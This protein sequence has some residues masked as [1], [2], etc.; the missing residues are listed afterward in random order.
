MFTVTE[1]NDGAL[2]RFEMRS[3]TG[4]LESSFK[5]NPYDMYLPQKMQEVLNELKMLKSKKV[6]TPE[7]W[8]AFDEDLAYLL[9]AALG[10]NQEGSMFRKY[11]PTEQLANGEVLC[12]LIVKEVCKQCKYYVEKRR[13]M[14]AQRSFDYKKK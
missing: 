9:S 4:E 7:E 10:G 8:A 11:A 14:F 3:E 2:L 6:T 13:A 12:V 1:I 5:V